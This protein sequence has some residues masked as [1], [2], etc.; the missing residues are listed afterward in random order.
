MIFPYD[1]VKEGKMTFKYEDLKVMLNDKKLILSVTLV[2]FNL[3]VFQQIGNCIR[4]LSKHKDSLCT[5][6]LQAF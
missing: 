5:A 2:L 4:W 3:M 6:F 1:L